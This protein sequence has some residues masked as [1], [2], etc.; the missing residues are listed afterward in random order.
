MGASTIVWRAART[1]AVP[2][3]AVVRLVAACYAMGHNR[4]SA[5]QDKMVE[6]PFRAHCILV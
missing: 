4:P 2:S 6:R 5:M 3:T 1:S